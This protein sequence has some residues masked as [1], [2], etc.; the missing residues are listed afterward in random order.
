MTALRR[1][2]GRTRLGLPRGE[3]NDTTRTRDVATGPFG[4]KPRGD[5]ANAAHAGHK[6]QRTAEQEQVPARTL[7][8]WWLPIL[9]SAYK[10]ARNTLSSQRWSWRSPKWQG[11]QWP[12]PSARRRQGSSEKKH[13]RRCAKRPT[14]RASVGEV[15]RKHHKKPEAARKTVKDLEARTAGGE[16]ERGVR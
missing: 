12:H 10:S 9:L 7:A 15:A 6:E 3:G 5:G 4:R 8:T 1:S 14:Q 16:E 11:K 2:D 13:P